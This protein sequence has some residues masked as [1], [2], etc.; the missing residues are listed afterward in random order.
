MAKNDKNEDV[1]DDVAPEEG[2]VK[3]WKDGE[4][5]WVHPS[6]VAAHEEAGWKAV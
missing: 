3:V 4:G 1:A 6:C 5:L 2:L